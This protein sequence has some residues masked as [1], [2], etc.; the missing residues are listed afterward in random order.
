MSSE[1]PATAVDA[2]AGEPVAVEDAPP[3]T[4]ITN[5]DGDEPAQGDAGAAGSATADAPTTT[6]EEGRKSAETQH[7]AAAAA[8]TSTTTTPAAAVA[9]TPAAPAVSAPAASEFA[10]AALKK[11]VL[12]FSSQLC[13]INTLPL[14]HSGSNSSSS[15]SRASARLRSSP[16][17]CE[18]LMCIEHV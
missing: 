15:E 18:S 4:S 1:E 6:Q 11:R 12:S 16:A 9:Q 13:T 10:H 14:S 7:A 3:R 5:N 8:S 17:S 2:S